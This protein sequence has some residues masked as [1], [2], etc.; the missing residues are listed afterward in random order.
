M[1][2]QPPP[3]VD[4]SSNVEGMS[5]ALPSKTPVSLLQELCMR[6]GIS[7][8]YDLLQIEGA[9]HEPTFVYRVTVGEFAANGSGQSKKKAKHAAA[10]AVLDIIIQGGAAGAGGPTSGGAPG[11]PPELSTQIVS[12]YDD[13]IP[14]NP[15]G[16][17]QELCMARR[18]PPPTYEL[19]SEEGFPHERTFSIA[20]TIGNTREIGTGKSKKLAKRQAAYKMT[21]LLKDQPVEAP[22]VNVLADDDD[23]IAQKLAA[24]YSGLKDSKVLSLTTSDSRKTISLSNVNLNFVQML[25][26]IAQE[27]NFVVTYVDIEELSVSGQHQCLVQLSTLPVAVCYGTGANVKEAQSAAAHNALEYLRIMTNK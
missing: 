23:E 16:S 21:Q 9:V 25:Q 22:Q 15:V 19:T 4:S 12:P 3:N 26:D 5:G 1:Y 8:K 24:R 20:C 27:A 6:R 14:G 17:L 10:K 18:W 7:P 13:G 2:H 11:A